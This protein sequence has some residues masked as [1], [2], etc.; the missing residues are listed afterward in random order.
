VVHFDP[1]VPQFQGRKN[2]K[3][4]TTGGGDRADPNHFTRIICNTDAVHLIGDASESR[5]IPINGKKRPDAEAP[6]L[7]CS[8]PSYLP[9]GF[10]CRNALPALPPRRRGSD[11]LP[12][13]QIVPAA[14]GPN[15]PRPAGGTPRRPARRRTAPTP[16]GRQRL[17]RRW[18]PAPRQ[19]SGRVPG[20]KAS[21]GETA[22]RPA[23]PMATSIR[24]GSAWVQVASFGSHA[25][26]RKDG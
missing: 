20:G 11:P 17:P 10:L 8:V 18:Q 3:C 4:T 26:R 14:S 24:Q 2:S 25:R 15:W 5:T 21:S 22:G 13:L 7:S 9:L 6:G 16:R 12:L 19:R 23:N 1:A